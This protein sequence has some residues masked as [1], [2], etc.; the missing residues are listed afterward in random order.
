MKHARTWGLLMVVAVALAAFASPAAATTIT[1]SAGTTPSLS[2]SA[3]GHVILDNQIA[4]IECAS[5]LSGK[6]ESHGAGVTV[7]GKISS[8]SFTSCTNNWHV[9]VTVNGSFEFHAIGGDGK[10]TVSGAAFEAT[11]F[12][13]TCRYG[14]SSTDFGTGTDGVNATMDIQAAIPS[15]GGSGLCGSA[16]TTLTGSYKINSPTNVSFHA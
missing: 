11:R 10:L 5:S 14:T 15:E 6:V 1:S 2:M 8:L 3:E 12:G 16:A 13:I 4:K 7:K 9:T